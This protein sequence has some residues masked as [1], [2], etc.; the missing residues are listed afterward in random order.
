MSLV[1]KQHWSNDY[2]AHHAAVDYAGTNYK[3]QKLSSSNMSSVLHIV[4]Q[5]ISLANTSKKYFRYIL[6]MTF[7]ELYFVF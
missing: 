6:E 7:F 5:E 4:E 1:T 2:G 3:K